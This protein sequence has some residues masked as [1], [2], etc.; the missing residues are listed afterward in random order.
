MTGYCVC[1]DVYEGSLDGVVV[2]HFEHVD[3]CVKMFFADCRIVSFLVLS[4]SMLS[5]AACL[6]TLWFSLQTAHFA[7]PS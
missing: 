5:E 6:A 2:L 3:N 4:S 7:L 1:V